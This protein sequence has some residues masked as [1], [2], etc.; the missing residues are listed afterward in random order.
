MVVEQEHADRCGGSG[1][2]PTLAH[3][4][5]PR[6][7]PWSRDRGSNGPD[8]AGTDRETIV[9]SRGRVSRDVSP[10]REKAV[11]DE[12]HQPVRAD[13]DGRRRLPDVAPGRRVRDHPRRLEREQR[14][15]R[16]RAR[17][18]WRLTEF[19]HRPRRRS[20]CRIG[21]S[22]AGDQQRHHGPQRGHHRHR[23][24]SR[25]TS[26]PAR[27][28]PLDVS[29]LDPGDY[30]I[31]CAIS[32]HKDSGMTGHADH[33]R[34]QRRRQ[35]RRRQRRPTTWPAWTTARRTSARIESGRRRGQAMNKRME[36]G[37]DEGRRRLPGQRRASTPT[38]RS[39]PATRSIEPDDPGRRHQALQ[40]D[41]CG[42]RLGGQPGQG[43]QGVDLQRHGPRPV[44]QGRA[45]RQGRGGP[46]QQPAHQ[47]RHPLARH[48]ASPTTRTAWPR[49]TQD[50]IRPNDDLHLL[51][52][53]RRPLRARRCTTPTCH[54]QEAVLNG[55]FAV[56]Q[57]GDVPLPEGRSFT[58]SSRSPRT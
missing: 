17:S 20:S 37:M 19:A 6:Q 52:H 25:R 15:R 45:R 35:R 23:P 34:R 31:F 47:H 11:P 8:A 16:S 13:E 41:R 30:E 57:V 9:P 32:G 22:I 2:T 58:A 43:R 40:P 4:T 51:L 56:F 49:I 36:D 50:Y 48:R 21:G 24:S 5:R 38:A 33:Q 12:F 28:R 14:D 1:H 42:H 27:P 53:R 55:L 46:H 7:G 26:R 44:D 29:S 18:R 3:R 39:R 10:C 54:G